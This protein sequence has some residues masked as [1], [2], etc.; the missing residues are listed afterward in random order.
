MVSLRAVQEGKF[1]LDLDVNSILKSW[2]LPTGD[3]TRE[4]SVTPRALMSHLFGTGDGFGFS[5]Y[6]VGAPLP[7]IPQILDGVRPSNLRAVRLERPPVGG[8]KTPAAAS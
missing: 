7:T 2:K 3:F 1:A 5:G 4:R 8:H 6:A